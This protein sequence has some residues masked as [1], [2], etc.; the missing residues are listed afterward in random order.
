MRVRVWRVG[1]AIMATPLVFGACRGD[2]RHDGIRNTGILNRDSSRHAGAGDIQIV[3]TDSALELSIIGDTVISGLGPKALAKIKSATDTGAV[4]GSGFAA[5]LEK[6]VKSS[7]QTALNKQLAFPVSS[8]GDV[9]F[10]EGKVQ[11]FDN[12]GKRVASFSDNSSGEKSRG[13]MFT[14]S[15]AEAFVRVFRAKKAAAAH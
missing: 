15:D 4:T 3:S 10:E 9:R 8:V 13:G 12:A 14:T 5:K 6:L 1:V 11:F 7:V 2:S